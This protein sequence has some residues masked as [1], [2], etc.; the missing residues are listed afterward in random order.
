MPSPM[1]LPATSSCHAHSH[2]TYSVEKRNS[3]TLI[4]SKN[5]VDSHLF[6]RKTQRH[7]TFSVEKWDTALV[8]TKHAFRALLP[9]W[10][11]TD[12]FPCNLMTLTQTKP[13]RELSSRFPV[14]DANLPFSQ[15]VTLSRPTTYHWKSFVRDFRRLEHNVTPSEIA[16]SAKKHNDTQPE[17]RLF[18]K[19]T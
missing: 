3:P 13:G 15:A 11:F 2:D 18:V 6:G 1:P 17:N 12:S 16:H 9:L 7:N 5:A 8:F 4:L 14:F 10:F 19:A